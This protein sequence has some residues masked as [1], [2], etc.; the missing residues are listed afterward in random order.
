MIA[1]M[2]LVSLYVDRNSPMM[3]ISRFRNVTDQ[4]ASSTVLNRTCVLGGFGTG[5]LPNKYDASLLQSRDI[6]LL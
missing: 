3:C 1:E 6:S 5:S 4:I 2:N